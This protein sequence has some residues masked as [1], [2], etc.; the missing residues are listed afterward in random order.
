M[1]YRFLNFE[2]DPERFELFQN[3]EKVVIQP[4]ALAILLMLVQNQGNLLP[5]QDMLR[6][7]WAART[8]SDSAL[9]SQIKALRRILGD[10]GQHQRVIE[11]VYGRGFRFAARVETVVSPALSDRSAPLPTAED[12]QAKRAGKPPVIAVL[13][14]CKIGEMAKHSALPEALP[15]DITT[16]L[17]QLRWL[18]VIARA[19]SFRF[20]ANLPDLAKMREELGV[21]YVLTGWVELVAGQM[22]V[23]VEL[24]ETRHHRV[25]WAERYDAPLSRI[26]D[27]RAQMVRDIISAIDISISDTEAALAKLTAP[28]QLTAWESYHLGISAVAGVRMDLKHALSHF[29]VA[30]TKAPAFSRAHAG[31]AYIHG[32]GL[33]HLARGGNEST[34]IY[35]MQILG[36]QA[37]ICDPLD[38]FAHLVKGRAERFSGNMDSAL[39]HYA[40]AIALC[41]NYAEAYHSQAV[42]LMLNGDFS[43]SYE[44]ARLAVKLNPNCPM[45]FEAE[46]TQAYTA[47]QLGKNEE[48]LALARKLAKFSQSSPLALLTA[49]IVFH[50]LGLEK[51]ASLVHSRVASTGMQLRTDML[52]TFPESAAKISAQVTRTVAHYLNRSAA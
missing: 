26:H 23:G 18:F 43:A 5:K 28:D 39:D 14:L 2:L 22:L 21:D 6:Q 8:I 37:L 49:M 12:E 9:S 15:A 24:T 38:P 48:A 1:K 32:L 20:D 19:S 31:A 17:S 46:S 3:G 42:I 50:H 44:A 7:L 10:D 27:V 33:Y 34:A 11:T 4:Q 52:R 16:A 41:P 47:F 35:N 45:R 40:K 13:P 51:E 25:V 36:E 29:E 30:R